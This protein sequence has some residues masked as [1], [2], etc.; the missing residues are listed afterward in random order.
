M[1]WLALHFLHLVQI[2]YIVDNYLLGL[3]IVEF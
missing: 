2:H 1:L 3:N